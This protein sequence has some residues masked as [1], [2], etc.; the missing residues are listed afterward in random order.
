MLVD[1]FKQ[2]FFRVKLQD[3]VEPSSH[4]HDHNNSVMVSEQPEIAEEPCVHRH[5]A[6][7]V[8]LITV[9]TIDID[10]GDQA[11][12]EKLFLII[13]AVLVE[14]IDR[15]SGRYSPLSERKLQR[16]HSP[17]FIFDVSEELIRYLNIFIDGVIKSCV[18]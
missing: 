1:R 11:C 4:G 18:N 16:N 15:V 13:H 5:I 3:L 10:A 6:I 2:L 12:S 14:N 7:V 9:E 17:H 8:V